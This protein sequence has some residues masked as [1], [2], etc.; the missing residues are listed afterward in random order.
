MVAGPRGLQL[1]ATSDR[2]SEARLEA[3]T[4]PFSEARSARPSAAKRMTTIVEAVENDN[5]A[6]N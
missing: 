3:A 5:D 2:R 4:A 6:L 1:A